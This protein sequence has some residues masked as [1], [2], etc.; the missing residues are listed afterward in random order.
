M[1]NVEALCGG[2]ANFNPEHGGCKLA[3]VTRKNQEERAAVKFCENAEV[4]GTDGQ[5]HQA[6]AILVPEEWLKK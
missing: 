3:W 6:P 2:C 5:T 1:T 4:Y